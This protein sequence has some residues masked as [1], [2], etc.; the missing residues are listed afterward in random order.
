M[1]LLGTWARSSLDTAER[2]LM[3]WAQTTCPT[4]TVNR[5]REPA[6]GGSPSEIWS[7]LTLISPVAPSYTE[8][9]ADLV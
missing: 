1:F 7:S 5:L 8:M 3:S 2:H 4:F 6:T 9:G